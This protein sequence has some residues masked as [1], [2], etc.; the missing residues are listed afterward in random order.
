MERVITLPGDVDAAIEQLGDIGA[1]MTAK[2]WE[3][4]ALVYCLTTD[5]LE[6]RPKKGVNTD[7]FPMKAFAKL[8][9]TGLKSRTPSSCIASGGRSTATQA[10]SW[11]TPSSCRPTTG[12]RPEPGRMATSRKLASTL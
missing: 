9:I 6:G 1:L 3:R 8:G 12:P 2:G 11:V 10:S 4:A 7:T 5:E